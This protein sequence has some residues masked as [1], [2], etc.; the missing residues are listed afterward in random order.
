MK[1]SLLQ[2]FIEL[3]GINT[4]LHI[5]GQDMEGLRS[6][7]DMRMRALK[8]SEPESYYDLLVADID[9]QRKINFWESESEWKELTLLVTT[10]ESYFFRD[11]GQMNLLETQILPELIEKQKNSRLLRI[12]SAGCSTG[13]EPYSLAILLQKMIPNWN[14]WQIFILG[15]DINKS[16]IEKAKRGI[17]SDWSF[18]MVDPALQNL[19]FDW[20]KKGWKI[21]ED[22]RLMVDFRYGNL[23][24]DDYPNPANDLY[25]IDLILCRN[26]FVYFS[27]TAIQ[28]V[29]NK[30]E[31]CL[32]VGGYL[33]TAHAELHGQNLNKMQS[34]VF[35]ESVIYQRIDTNLI[36]VNEE[37]KKSPTVQKSREDLS[38][39]SMVEKSRERLL[40]K[41]EK[42]IQYPWEKLTAIKSLG[43]PIEIITTPPPKAEFFSST[44]ENLENNPENL[45]K[46]AQNF[47]IVKAY[48]QTIEKIKKVL[49]LDPQN[50][51]AYYLMAQAHAN[52]GEYRQAKEATE[53]A[54][55]ID[56]LSTGP[57]YLLAQ[58]AE[59]QGDIEQA[60]MFWK[61]IIYLEPFSILAYLELAAL[62]ERE[63]DWFRAQKMRTNALN[64]LKSLPSESLLEDV[65]SIKV[66]ELQ[67]Y[68]EE[69]LK[70]PKNDN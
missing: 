62:Y 53:Q 61:R 45:L 55:S 37:F 36:L 6:K 26:V 52:L 58:L 40:N 21:K 28:A 23:V 32:K 38:Y 63:K 24:K 44:P 19:Y 5:R 15:T 50:F 29:L 33:L 46:E 57:Y 3:I 64:L 22:I 12:W 31:N 49:S 67:K 34:R 43:I 25:D 59:E 18:R 16:N 65:N 68:V 66:S 17:Y 1:H 20:H 41:G 42:Q 11:R 2:K 69:M 70:K 54:I 8:L 7:I 27:K 13:E 56:A 14:E 30:F 4:G 35:P 51:K 47:F 48:F 9:D 10:G 39:E 60:K